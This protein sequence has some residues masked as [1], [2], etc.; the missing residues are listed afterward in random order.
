[1]DKPEWLPEIVDVDGNWSDVF[2]MLHDIFKRDFIEGKPK[3][4]EKVIFWDRRVFV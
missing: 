3:L 1:M 4:D 2:K